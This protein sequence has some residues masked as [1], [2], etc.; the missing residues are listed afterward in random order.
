MAKT[1]IKAKV[2]YSNLVK[3]VE[4]ESWKDYRRLFTAV[5]NCKDSF[6]Y[7]S[8]GKRNWI[9]LS[10]AES[11]YVEETQLYDFKL[12]LKVETFDGLVLNIPIVGVQYM[13]RFWEKFKD[14]GLMLE[15]EQAKDVPAFINLR[16]VLSIEEEEEVR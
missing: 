3:T 1:Y 12:R 14:A 4:L 9:S 6:Y 13:N 2:V 8:K 16:N 10:G 7:E 15:F 5:L 11:V